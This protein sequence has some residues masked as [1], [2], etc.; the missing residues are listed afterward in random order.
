MAF[1]ATLL[2]EII[3]A[4]EC[5]T[6][7]AVWPYVII[8]SSSFL[9]KLKEVFFKVVTFLAILKYFPF[10]VIPD[11]ATFWATFNGNWATF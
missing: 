5:D 3:V 8:K 4:V 2:Y 11:E 6:S 10:W 9:T 1:F 7:W